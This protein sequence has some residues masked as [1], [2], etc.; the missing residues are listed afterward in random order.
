MIL[1]ETNSQRNW[2]A[3]NEAGLFD[4]EMAP[5]ELESRKG[6][7]IFNT[8]EHPRPEV[9]LEKLEKLRPVFKKDGVVTAANAS[10]ICDGA[11]AIILASEEAVKVHNLKPLARIVSYGITGCDPK[12]M[13]IGPVS[14]IQQVL[15]RASLTIDDMDRIEINEAFAAQ[16][17]ACAT[18]LGLDMDKTNVNGG[19]ISLGHPTGA[20]GKPLLFWLLSFLTNIDWSGAH[21]VFY[22]STIINTRSPDSCSSGKRFS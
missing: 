9:T 6:T 3:A 19:A 5:I 16:F 21:A 20:S 14:A 1:V 7:Q 15:S 13:G 22:D 8:D 11:G 12:I 10:G 4:E 18:E 17:L 2:K